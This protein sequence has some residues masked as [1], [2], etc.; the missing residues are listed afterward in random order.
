[1]AARY[2]Q[3]G[4]S[5]LHWCAFDQRFPFLNQ[6]GNINCGIMGTTCSCS[7]SP[8]CSR[9]CDLPNLCSFSSMFM[10]VEYYIHLSFKTKFDLKLT[11]ALS[12]TRFKGAL[13]L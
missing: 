8:L 6:T 2:R 5:G 4:H 10:G 12:T 3:V 13:R 1:M 7:I 9:I 11:S